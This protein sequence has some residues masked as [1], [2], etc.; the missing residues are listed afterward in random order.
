MSVHDL[1]C[2]FIIWSV[3]SL[4]LFI[5]HG[6]QNVL[7]VMHSSFFYSGICLF[8]LFTCLSMIIYIY[9]YISRYVEV[10]LFAEL[11][12]VYYYHV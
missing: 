1:E 12:L 2:L 3:F 8:I 7:F 9:S 11:T 6:I 10:D 5:V 4:C